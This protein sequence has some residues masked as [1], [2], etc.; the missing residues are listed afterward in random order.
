MS[1]NGVAFLCCST[2]EMKG[3]PMVADRQQF[4]E[5]DPRHHTIKLKAM[6]PEAWQ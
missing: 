1:T 4:G 2:S 5:T 6:L 3:V